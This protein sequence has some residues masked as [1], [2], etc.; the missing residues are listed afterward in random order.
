MISNCQKD[1][2]TWHCIFPHNG[3]FFWGLGLWLYF[4]IQ[5]LPLPLAIVQ[6]ISPRSV[7]FAQLALSVTQTPELSVDQPAWLSLSLYN[8]PVR[9]AIV[10]YTVYLF[11]F[12]GFSH[13]LSTKNRIETAIW[14]ILILGVLES[15]YG[16]S[17]VFSKTGYILWFSKV[18]FYSVKDV[19]GTYINKNHFAGLMEMCLILALSYIAA[20]SK[21]HTSR[22]KK[23]SLKKRLVMMVSFEQQ[24]SKRMVL[25]YLSVIMG[26]GLIFSSSRAG[27]ISLG[28]GI[29]FTTLLYFFRKKYRKTSFLFLIISLIFA[30]YAM[31]IGM[32]YPISKF[33]N[34]SNSMEV[35]QRMTY[36]TFQMAKDYIWTCIGLGNFEYGYPAYQAKEDSGISIIHAH[37]DWIQYFAESGL[38]GFILFG[39]GVVYFIISTIKLW[40]KR[41]DPFAIFL[42]TA[43]LSVMVAIGVHSCFD[44]NLHIPANGLFLT[45]ILSIGF[46]SLRV[47]HH[48]GK[49]EISL[50][51][52]Q[53][54]PIMSKASISIGLILIILIGSL[55][56]SIRHFIAEINC[57]T[58]PNS[59]LKWNHDPDINYIQNAIQWDAWNA[60]YWNQLSWKLKQQRNQEKIHL[61]NQALY[62]KQIQI[63][64]TLEKALS[65][66]P[67]HAEYLMRL[68]WEYEYL[69]YHK[70]E[71]VKWHAKAD[72]AMANVPKL[73]GYQNPH[74]YFEIGNY[75]VMR[76]TQMENQEQSKQARIQA[77]ESY[78]LAIQLKPKKVNWNHLTKHI[79]YYYP[80]IK[81]WEDYT[82][83]CQ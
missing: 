26:I 34:M 67:Y 42:G 11:F 66:N 55:T 37:N 75:W 40:N 39:L 33:Q 47:V 21:K 20:L 81:K 63:I 78:K 12:F 38:I 79:S 36:Q 80:T 56:W 24:V 15:L 18:H 9:L 3:L 59:T 51:R 82:Q 62:D 74:H 53:S 64:H 49:D 16:L 1:L 8:Y 29:L 48:K 27:I 50:Y 68:A 19:T 76:S 60:G 41:Q 23:N 43:P 31:Y 28:V 54:M 32:D 45:A 58:V 65:L 44:F 77:C 30:I 83:L 72:H 35:R 10:Q 22:Y 57:Q 6:L 70:E 71:S 52:V 14:A 2:N 73:T 13:V 61:S 46:R 5:I 17:Q 4:V 69:T 25:T 7:D